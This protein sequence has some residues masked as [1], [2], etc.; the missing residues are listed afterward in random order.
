MGVAIDLLES[1]T[2]LLGVIPAQAGIQGLG[3]SGNDSERFAPVVNP[4]RRA[5]L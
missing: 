2:L 1:L 3:E 5:D 4:V